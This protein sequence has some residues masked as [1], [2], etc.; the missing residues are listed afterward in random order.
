MIMADLQAPIDH[1][2]AAGKI[3]HQ[4]WEN[5][6]PVWNDLVHQRFEKNYWAAI[7]SLARAMLVDLRHL[8]QAIV[9]AQLRAHQV[10]LFGIFTCQVLRGVPKCLSVELRGKMQDVNR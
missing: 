4:C 7:E 10:A 6:Q 3:L 9:E 8:A 1:L 5:R 2:D